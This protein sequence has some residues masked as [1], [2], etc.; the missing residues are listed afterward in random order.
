M[1]WDYC[2]PVGAKKKPCVE[3]MTG[4]GFD[5]RGCQTKTVSGRTCQSWLTNTPHDT[6]T[7][8]DYLD[9]VAAF[10]GFCR[11]TKKPLAPGKTIWC[12]TTDP[13]KR[14]EYCKPL[15]CPA[16]R[17]NV[18]FGTTLESGEVKGTLIYHKGG[19]GFVFKDRGR[20]A[21][22]LYHPLRSN[23][24]DK[25]GTVGTAA[26]PLDPSTWEAAKNDYKLESLGGKWA[27]QKDRLRIRTEFS[28]YPG[29]CPCPIICWP[30][31]VCVEQY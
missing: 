21:E 12:Y 10:D 9:P 24:A 11:N 27:I 28:C 16:A 20:G 26:D 3:S 8:E 31:A 6:A 23:G 19:T 13:D 14:F 18:T 25:K 2:L 29:F 7:V 15:D 4:E 30:G 22:V 5:Y 17:A 1:K